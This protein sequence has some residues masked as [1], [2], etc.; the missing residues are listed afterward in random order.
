[1][2][3]Y[4]GSSNSSKH[5]APY[6]PYS[7][8][9][10]LGE[11]KKFKQFKIPSPN[12]DVSLLGEFKKFQKFKSQQRCFSTVGV[13]TNQSQEMMFLSLGSSKKQKRSNAVFFCAVGFFQGLSLACLV[14]FPAA[15]HCFLKVEFSGVT[16]FLLFSWFFSI[17]L[18]VCLLSLAAMSFL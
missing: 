12:S 16:C 1:M 5:R 14:G 3:L 9:S 7:D 11:F 8:V 17:G 18:S 13:Q 6:R 4:L 15:F 2:F 10:L